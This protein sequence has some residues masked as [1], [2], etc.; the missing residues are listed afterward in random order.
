M[1]EATR[2]K[3]S[4]I[5]ASFLAA[6]GVWIALV[7]LGAPSWATFGTAYIAFLLFRVGDAA[8]GRP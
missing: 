4:N 5:I 6:L 3:A 2:Q 7:I 8:R 1:K